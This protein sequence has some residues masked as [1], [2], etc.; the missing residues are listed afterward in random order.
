M[1]RIIKKIKFIMSEKKA[2]LLQMKRSVVDV[3]NTVTYI[4][5]PQQNCETMSKKVQTI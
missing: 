1:E 2:V 5:T 3:L 4:H